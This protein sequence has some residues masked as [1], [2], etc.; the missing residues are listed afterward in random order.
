MNACSESTKKIDDERLKPVLSKVFDGEFDCRTLASRHCDD[1]TK[2]NLVQG[3]CACKCDADAND[4]IGDDAN[5]EIAAFVAAAVA[6]LVIVVVFRRQIIFLFRFAWNFF[7]ESIFRSA[8]IVVAVAVFVYA[9][10]VFAKASP[11]VAVGIAFVTA[12][13]L[14]FAWTSTMR[15]QRSTVATQT[16]VD[17]PSPRRDEVQWIDFTQG[18]ITSRF[19]RVRPARSTEVPRFRP[20]EQ[21]T[22]QLLEGRERTFSEYEDWLAQERRRISPPSREDALVERLLNQDISTYEQEVRDFN[23]MERLNRLVPEARRR[24]RAPSGEIDADPT[25]EYEDW[26]AQERRR[27][28][29]PSR[30][31]AYPDGSEDV[32]PALGNVAGELAKSDL[33]E[34]GNNFNDRRSFRL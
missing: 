6:V 13:L 3:F 5:D 32:V 31:D 15:R 26:L 18:V 9:T 29:P 20:G 19:N 23:M 33:Y 1:E 22:P 2:K 24:G 25:S 30:E 12:M 34:L 27:I 4:E 16:S 7:T 10:K 11:I 14:A 28:S 17:V 21:N 8:I